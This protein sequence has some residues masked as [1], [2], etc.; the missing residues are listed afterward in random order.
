M[1]EI[2]SLREELKQTQLAYQMAMQMSQ[3]K[4]GFLARISHELRSPLTS[5]IGLHQLIL[6]DLCESPEEQKAFISQAYQSALKLMGLIDEI[7]DIAKTAYGTKE[8]SLESIS[9]L[10]ILNNVR[11]LTHLQAA[12]RNLKLQFV[13]PDSSI[14]VLTDSARLVQALLLVIDSAI[15]AMREGNICISNH[16]DREL[17]ITTLDI[18]TD[19]PIGVWGDSIDLSRQISQLDRHTI[20]LFDL[21]IDLSPGMK[22]MLSQALL[23]TMQ[24]SLQLLDLSNQSSEKSL[25][26]LRCSIPLAPSLV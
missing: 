11:H 18:D 21:P 22:L 26:R 13:D 10:S 24:G 25:T 5:L 16:V 15:G 17:K 20:E 19:C 4:A 23:E 1:D 12:N 8:L 9:L 3:F 6:S 14:W 7:V 2:E